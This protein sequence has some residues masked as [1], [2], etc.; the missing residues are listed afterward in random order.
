MSFQRD[1]KS[2]GNSNKKYAKRGFG[3]G[4]GGRDSARPT[5]HRAICSECNAECEVPFKPSGE[6]PAFCRKCFKNRDETVPREFSKPKNF[7]GGGETMSS[8]Q[9]NILN[10]KLDR[11]LEKL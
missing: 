5:L 1:N 6:K 3:G 4:F 10:S 8:E 2:G 9:F 7:G 11:I